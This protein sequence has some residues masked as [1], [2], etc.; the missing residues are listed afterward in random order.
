MRRHV[1]LVA[2][3]LAIAGIGATLAGGP[4]DGTYHGTLTGE[5]LNAVSCAKNAPVQMTVTDNKLEYHHFSNATITATVAADGS[6][7]GSAQNKYAARGAGAPMIQ[8]LDGKITGNAIK[9]ETKV[10]NSCTYGLTLKKF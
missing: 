2:P 5:G 4:Y 6:F 10:S 9:A 7:S 3:I 8:T 1:V